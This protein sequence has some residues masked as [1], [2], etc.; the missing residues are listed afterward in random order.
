MSALGFYL[1]SFSR[2][3]WNLQIFF[4]L[5]GRMETGEP[6][7]KPSVNQN[8]LTTHDAIQRS[9][10]IEPGSH[11]WDAV[12][13]TIVTPLHQNPPSRIP[14]LLITLYLILWER[15]MYTS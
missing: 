13:P 7:E 12:A 10:L 11:W 2:T 14:S 4:F 9:R 5:E 6:E 3:Y 1:G 8:N 15:Y